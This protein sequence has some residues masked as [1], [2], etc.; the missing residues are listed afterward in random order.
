MYRD[1]QQISLAFRHLSNH[2]V[3]AEEFVF[4]GM[5]DPPYEMF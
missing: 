5:K 4:L 3:F 2:P 1:E